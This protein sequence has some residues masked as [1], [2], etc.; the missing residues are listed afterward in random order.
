VLA[1]LVA[2]RRLIRHMG[3]LG[4]LRPLL[5][6][7]IKLVGEGLVAAVRIFPQRRD[8]GLIARRQRAGG[9]LWHFTNPQRGRNPAR[10]V[11]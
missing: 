7:R 1:L 3:V 5:D 2:R 8:E 9:I 10:A 6:L 4:D 11:G